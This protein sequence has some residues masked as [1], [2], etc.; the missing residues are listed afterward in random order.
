MAITAS[1]VG[2]PTTKLANLDRSVIG[3][4]ASPWLS[5]EREQIVGSF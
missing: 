4:E 5:R 2:A 3:C 1:G